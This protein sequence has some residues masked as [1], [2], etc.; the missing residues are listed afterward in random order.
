MWYISVWYIVWYI[1]LH[2]LVCLCGIR[3]Y[4]TLY[5]A[6]WNLNTLHWSGGNNLPPTVR[7]SARAALIHHP[8]MIIIIILFYL[9]KLL[10]LLISQPTI[11]NHNFHIVHMISVRSVLHSYIQSCQ[12]WTIIIIIVIIVVVLKCGCVREHS[13]DPIRG[14]LCQ[15]HISAQ[16]TMH[17]QN[18][19]QCTSKTL[20]SAHLRLSTVHI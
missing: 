5:I 19:P 9:L 16:C 20:H 7:Q 10:D 15:L 6:Q 8:S 2:W 14:F 3:T 17:I 4:L 12:V 13:L 11:H 18:S 1:M